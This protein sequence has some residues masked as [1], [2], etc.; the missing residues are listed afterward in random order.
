MYITNLKKHF[1]KKLKGAIHI[2]AHL[3]EEKRWYNENEINPV[4][5]IEANPNLID[6]LKVNVGNDLIIN[7]GV[8]DVNEEKYFNIANNGQSSSL[9][10]LGTHKIKH[11][12][13]FYT[14][15]ILI[16]TKRM[17]DLVKTYSIDLAQYNFLNLDIQGSE[18]DAIKSFDSLIGYF[19]Y[20][21]TEVNIEHLYENCS[22]I[23]EIDDYLKK[24]N[25]QRAETVI[26]PYKWGDAFYV[27]K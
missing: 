14:N 9:L 2:G 21:Y 11:S 24:F 8:S 7:Y 22:L 1:T 23:D 15:K 17:S 3:G 25:F 26:T 20:I 18:L 10:D 19:D 6:K 27:K 5:W 13:V 4:I 16:E 12:D